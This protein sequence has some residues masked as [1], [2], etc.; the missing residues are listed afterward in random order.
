MKRDREFTLSHIYY[1]SPISRELQKSITVFCVKCF[2]YET[3]NIDT[4]AIDIAGWVCSKLYCAECTY[5]SKAKMY[6]GLKTPFLQR[7][8]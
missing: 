1:N 6:R 5:D 8:V 2:T 4:Q 3:E 7:A